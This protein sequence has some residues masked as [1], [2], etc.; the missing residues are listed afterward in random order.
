MGRN[1]GHGEEEVTWGLKEQDS[2]MIHNLH[3]SPNVTCIS[4]TSVGGWEVCVERMR[5][6]LTRQNNA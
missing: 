5:E 3:C 4:V 1:I 2:G 6:I